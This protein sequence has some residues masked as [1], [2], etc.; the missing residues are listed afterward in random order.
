M[1]GPQETP[2]W[3]KSPGGENGNSLQNSC[4]ENP[5]DR[6]LVATVHRVT[7]TVRHDWSHWGCRH[8]GNSSSIFFTFKFI[9]EE[10][11]SDAFSYI[12]FFPV[13]YVH[14]SEFSGLTQ[15]PCCLLIL[16]IT[17]CTCQSQTPNLSLCP[18]LPPWQPLVC[19]LSLWVSWIL[20]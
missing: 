6:S 9:P 18:R 11:K 10:Y 17:M 14:A 20:L 2:G 4:L 7:Q 3:G 1:W 13:I 16:N 15:D 12:I 19:A 8:R 5:T